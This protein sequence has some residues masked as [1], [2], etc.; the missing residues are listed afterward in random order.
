M[1]PSTNANPSPS[2]HVEKRGFA[3]VVSLGLMSF[4]LLLL[5]AFTTLTQVE[6]ANATR[7]KDL[8]SARMNALLALN[9][10]LGELQ[11]A[12][13]VDT[14]VTASADITASFESVV[15]DRIN[16]ASLA[17]PHYTLVW[18]VSGSE[19]AAPG[20]APG[21]DFAR[22]PAVLVSG[23]ELLSHTLT[24]PGPYPSGYVEPATALSP[25]ASVELKSNG[26]SVRAPWVNLDA[27][28]LGASGRY[29]WWIGDEGV[30]AR[31][32]TPG[33]VN[34]VDVPEAQWLTAHYF[35]VQGVDPA[36]ASLNT[37]DLRTVFNMNA[38]PFAD[39]SDALQPNDG[40]AFYHDFS[41][42]SK[43]LLTNVRDGGLKKDLSYG[44]DAGNPAPASI[45]DRT[46][47]FPR[48][49]GG[50]ATDT[51]ENLN[52]AQWGLLRNY[53][54][55]RA[56]LNG[57]L[58]SR[59]NRAG[60]TSFETGVHPVISSFQIGFYADFEGSQ[61]RLWYMPAVT[62]W[63]PYTQDLI[64][65]IMHL[66]IMQYQGD[67]IIQ[68]RFSVEGDPDVQDVEY[69]S[70]SMPFTI[71]STTIPAGQAVVFSAPDGMSTYYPGNNF[72]NYASPN[73]S[74]RNILAPGYRQGSAFISQTGITSNLVDDDTPNTDLPRLKFSFSGAPQI[75][76]SFSE[77]SDELR[78]S[79]RRYQYLS[80]LR[81]NRN[82]GTSMIQY[83][84]PLAVFPDPK[85]LYKYTMPFADAKSYVSA[86]ANQPIAW[87]SVFNPRGVVHSFTNVALGYRDLPTY[88]G[89]YYADNDAESFNAVETWDSAGENR[90][91][92]TSASSSG[93]REAVLYNIPQSPLS[94]IAQLAHANIAA[95]VGSGNEEAQGIGRA[96]GGQPDGMTDLGLGWS[97]AGDHHTPNYAIGSSQ[98]P[99]YL[100]DAGEYTHLYDDSINHLQRIW[101]YS[102]L[103]NDVLFDKYFFS[104]IPQSGSI[105]LPFLNP[106]VQPIGN[107]ST[108]SLRNFDDAAQH[109]FYEGGFNINSTS[110]M[111]WA[112]FLSAM[113]ETDFAGDGQT[114]A[115][116][117]RF[118]RPAGLALQGVDLGVNEAAAVTGYHR[119]TDDM[120]IDLAE[121]IVEQV[122]LRGPFPSLSAF[123]NRV[124][125][126]DSLL[127][128]S[129]MLADNPAP[130]PYGAYG[131]GYRLEDM[132]QLKGA[133][134][135]ALEL[136]E[137]NKPFHDNPNYL[138]RAGDLAGGPAAARAFAGSVGAH[139]PAYTSQVDLLSRLGAS[140]F[141]RSDSFVIRVVG[142]SD[143]LSGESQSRVYAEARVQRTINYIDPVLNAPD[144]IPVVADEVNERFGR[145]FE[146]VDFRWLPESDI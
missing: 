22:K 92:G 112:A 115:F 70:R 105:T 17:H 133:L 64:C 24:Q 31:M 67:N 48:D 73:V 76:L 26:S 93:A 111:A 146:I 99:P 124:L 25:A 137:A 119:L 97:S 9:I 144:E 130:D 4:V 52:F 90:F 71:P 6:V 98:M 11:E 140:M 125:D 131:S 32:N 117:T 102:Y 121:R 23:N 21:H 107:P 135:A 72:N 118:D 28:N 37:E 132:V 74:N 15:N 62:L 122:K 128:S 103:L 68:L 42:F 109:L 5:L 57:Q 89:G 10:A 47:I 126:T 18:D 66:S 43:S 77:G 59:A 85:L 143:N 88:P 127:R 7:S 141:A 108:A 58:N 80:G 12:A 75:E 34:R 45:S 8:L 1:K 145:R 81:G 94:A 63:N 113:R 44:L 29:A 138:I 51:N 104:T 83:Y 36:L 27:G 65:P 142:E 3:L 54:N 96:L 49:L 106:L 60:S 123:V 134:H 13:G 86:D 78:M 40:N 110:V 33:P 120:I 61:I 55:L 114:G 30:K 84:P 2:S 50:A 101:D 41:F 53:Y 39:P 139:L 14:R 19:G 95:P 56:D 35:P 79:N 100:P 38:L 129:Q 116:F 87:S 46:Y 20:D 16:F 69:N 136:S 91:V 82:I